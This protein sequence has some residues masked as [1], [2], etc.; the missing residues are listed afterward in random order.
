MALCSFLW[1]ELLGRLNGM[2]LTAQVKLCPTDE[3]RVLLKQ[4]LEAANAACNAISE[5]AWVH[6]V[7]HQFNLHKALYADVRATFALAAQIVVRCLG[8]VADSYKTDKDTQHTFKAH[9]SIPYDNRILGY[10]QQTETVSIWSLGG[11]IAIPYQCGARQRDLLKHQ[12]GES[13]LWFHN[14]EFYL[15]ATCQIDEP[16]PEAV[17][18]FLGIDRGIV[19]LAVDNDGQIHKGSHINH[20]RHRH[21][22]LRRKLQKKGTK[23]ARR[24]LGQLAGKER[25]FAKDTNHCISKSIVAKAQGTKRGIALEDLDGIRDRVT[26]R[27]S[28]RAILHSWSFDDLDQKIRYKARRAG[29]QVIHVDPRNTSRTCPN[30]ACRHIDKRNRPSQSVFKCVVCGFSGLADHIAAIEISRRASVNKPDASDTAEDR[31]SARGKPPA[32]AGGS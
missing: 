16:T 6:Q 32:S 31:R 21:R 13:D 12:K 28:Q 26:V 1:F 17:H 25:R 2:K 10:R 3:Q 27:R 14:G 30:P 8:K 29:V 5:Y 23:S 15:L 18:E 4:T 20:I 19:N 24:L 7:F 22:R 11:R 9:G